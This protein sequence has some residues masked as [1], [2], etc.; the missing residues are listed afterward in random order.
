MWP[1]HVGKQS[2]L[3]L[4]GGRLQVLQA[5]LDKLEQPEGIQ[6]IE[7]YADCPVEPYHP[8]TECS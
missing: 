1:L 7:H 5:T 4:C 3:L 6:P 2:D 8:W